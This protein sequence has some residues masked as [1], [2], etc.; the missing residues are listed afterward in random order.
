MV[1]ISPK[2]LLELEHL[3]YRIVSAI[4][5]FFSKPANCLQRTLTGTFTT[6]PQKETIISFQSKTTHS[7]RTVSVEKEAIPKICFF[8]IPING[9]NL[10]DLAN[11]LGV[12]AGTYL[13]ANGL[14]EPGLPEHDSDFRL[15]QTFSF[16]G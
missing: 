12:K 13:A 10:D 6:G 15:P 3:T 5:A 1:F 4:A 7:D 14:C 2:E 16:F 9:M 11:L 8:T